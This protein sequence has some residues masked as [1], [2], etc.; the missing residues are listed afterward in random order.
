MYEVYEAH[1]NDPFKF[2]GEFLLKTD[3]L[4]QAASMAHNLSVELE[5]R[6]YVVWQP[7]IRGLRTDCCSTDDGE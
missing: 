2:V 1:V 7:S 4:P 3:S 5:G 6:R